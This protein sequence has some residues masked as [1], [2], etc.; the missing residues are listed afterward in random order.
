MVFTMK[1]LTL[2][3]VIIP[4]IGGTQLLIRTISPL[5]GIVDLTK[6]PVVL[7]NNLEVADIIIND[8][9]RV[10]SEHRALHFSVQPANYLIISA[11]I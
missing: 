6:G 7:D 11:A 4:V 9:C 5:A 2:N 3:Q 8:T 10:C 1:P